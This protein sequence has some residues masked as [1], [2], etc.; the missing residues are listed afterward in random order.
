MRRECREPNIP[1]KALWAR[2]RWVQCEVDLRFVGT[3]DAG[4]EGDGA[5]GVVIIQPGVGGSVC[6]LGEG[7]IRWEVCSQRGFD[8]GNGEVE[9][10]ARG[11]AG[12]DGEEVVEEVMLQAEGHSLEDERL[13]TM[14][15]ERLPAKIADRGE[16][17]QRACENGCG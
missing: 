1:T 6:I 2:G 13:Q 14:R 7:K 9:D 8:G 5:R 4:G 12:K 3:G 10:I 17:E 11:R 15:C 16:G